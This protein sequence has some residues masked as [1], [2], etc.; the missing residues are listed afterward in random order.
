L[1]E[2]RNA[3]ALVTAAHLLTQQTKG[4]DV[5]RHEAKWRLARMLYE[6]NWNKQRVVDLFNIVDWMMRLPP[7]L[8]SRLMDDVRAFEREQNMPY[9][10]SFQRLGREEGR[11]E[12][13]Q[14]GRE[15]GRQEGR[16]EGREEGRMQGRKEG[17][18]EGREEGRTQGRQEMLRDMLVKRFGTLPSAV[19]DRLSRA[20]EAEL[21]TWGLA[22][23]T[24]P[25]LQSVFEAR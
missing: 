12:G 25:T 11:L 9:I 4:R 3:F 19:E 1:L 24:A 15:E 21:K 2:H 7:A 23:L 14:E 17:R 10:S 13:R 20:S 16:Q 18:E 6:R 22:L 5:Q 8:Q